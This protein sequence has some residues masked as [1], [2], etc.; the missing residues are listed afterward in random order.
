MKETFLI[1]FF[2][3]I[4]LGEAL[5][6]ETL[7][8]KP[9]SSHVPRPASPQQICSPPDFWYQDDC[10]QELKPD[11]DCNGEVLVAQLEDQPVYCRKFQ[12]I[13]LNKNR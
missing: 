10:W 6:E 7:A 3:S 5:A 2:Y 13:K 8:A 9:E 1:I 4:I 11:E 12:V